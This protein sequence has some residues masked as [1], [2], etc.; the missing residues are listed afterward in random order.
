MAL[1]RAFAIVYLGVTLSACATMTSAG[2]ARPSPFPEPA[3][4]PAIFQP[5]PARPDDALPPN[6]KSFST[7][8]SDEH[9]GTCAPAPGTWAPW[10]G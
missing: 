6:V 1:A 10:L 7:S 4:K 3:S 2:V 9:A 5:E 8:H